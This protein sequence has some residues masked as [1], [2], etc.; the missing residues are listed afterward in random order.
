MTPPEPVAWDVAERVARRV[1][2]RTDTRIDWV[3]HRRLVADFEEVT[4]QAEAL[5]E[6]STGLRSLAGPAR[7][8]VASREAWIH[9]NISSFRRLLGPLLE[10]AGKNG[11]N[12]PGVLGPAGR[13]A[14]G[15]EMGVVL[16]WMSG[17]V[18]GQYDLLFA[19][20]DSPQD[21][22]YYVGPNIVSL[23]RRHGF[24]PREFRLWIAL[25]E[26]THRAQFTGVPWMRAHF[27]DLVERS[28]AIASPEPRQVMDAIGRMAVD[29]RAGRNPLAESGLVGALASPEQLETLRSIQGMMSLLEGHGD[30]TMDR[31]AL[32][33]IPSAARF[34]QVLRARRESASGLSKFFQQ[35]IGLDAKLRQ[36]KDG[37]RFVREIERTGGP[38]LLALAWQGPENL[39]TAAEIQEPDHWV[40]RVRGLA[41]EPA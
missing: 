4:A 7:A 24:E 10:R 33:L 2:R 17:R 6:Q 26:L 18:L 21:A 8:E 37:E 20:G 1:A 11:R 30:V 29:I 41:L 25:H 31:A 13:V 38:E 23:E 12:L 32:D 16:G 40:S 19:D 39:P 14:A 15:A 35:L 28:V 22:V 3:T 34:S 5:V 27:L 36:Y 9:A